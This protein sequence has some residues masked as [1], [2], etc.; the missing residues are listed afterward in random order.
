MSLWTSIF[1]LFRGAASETAEAI[2]DRN[3]LRI[4]DQQ[5]RDAEAALG[6]AQTDLAGL[7][8]RVK[9]TGNKVVELEQKYERDV[10]I[11]ERAVEQNKE[12]L[13][14]ELADRVAALEGELH[15][16]KELY[17]D[18]TAKEGQLKDTV[19]RIRQQIQAM[20]REVETVKVTESVQRAQEQVV[21]HGAGAASTL[22]NAAASLQRI[23]EKQAARTATFEAADQLTAL[24]SGGDLDRRLADAGLIGGPGSGASVLARIK[25]GRQAAALPPPPLQ[26]AASPEV[27]AQEPD[28]PR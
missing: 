27:I 21:N 14:R 3:V 24:Q 10:T 26:I 22:G 25:A 2:V 20:K 12:D 16:E 4:L 5:I 7:M 13:A 6:K 23:K 1:T 15:R 9:L 18:L 17:R 8:G 19:S 28:K 11:L